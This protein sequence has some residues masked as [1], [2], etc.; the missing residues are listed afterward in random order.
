MQP[1]RLRFGVA[2]GKLDN[3]DA[4]FFFNRDQSLKFLLK[5]REGR[6]LDTGPNQDNITGMFW[7]NIN[8]SAST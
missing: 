3:H 7:K 5:R 8:K 2:G 6:H 4:V 1:S